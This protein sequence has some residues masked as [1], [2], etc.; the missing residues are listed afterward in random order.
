MN[1]LNAFSQIIWK[2]HF[3]GDLSAVKDRAYHLLHTSQYLNSF[4]TTDG[5]VSSVEDTDG[6]HMWPESIELID[7]LTRQGVQRLKDWKFFH[8]NTYIDGSW[9][10][11]HP[12]GAWTKDHSHGNSSISVVVYLDQPENGG[13][14]EFQNP[15]FYHWSGYPKENELWETIEVNTGDVLMFPGWL[16]HRTQKN[17]SQNNRVVMSMNMLSFSD[18]MLIVPK[19][20]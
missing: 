7:W 2:G 13:N 19:T 10:N 6:P 11:L 16:V 17:L 14:L 9:V 4:L 15:L 1:P 5:G 18:D 8:P 20:F 3:P 12:P